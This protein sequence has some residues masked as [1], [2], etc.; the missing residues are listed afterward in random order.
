MHIRHKNEYV[1]NLNYDEINDCD[2]R[3][4]YSKYNRGI[5]LDFFL[6]FLLF[7]GFT[8]GLLGWAFYIFSSLRH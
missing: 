8:S 4:V 1:K 3:L 7:V 6:P 2:G 5:F